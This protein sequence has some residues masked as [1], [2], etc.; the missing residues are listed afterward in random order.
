MRL[1]VLYMG[2]KTFFI[3]QKYISKVQPIG[4]RWT[5]DK[6]MKCVG[7]RLDILLFFNFEAYFSE[8]GKVEYVKDEKILLL[9]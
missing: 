4:E 3:I 7:R 8:I 2:L 6:V 9:D 5:Q 1:T